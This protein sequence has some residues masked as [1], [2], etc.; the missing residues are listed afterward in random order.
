[1]ITRTRKADWWAPFIGQLALI[2]TKKGLDTT[3]E[4]EFKLC[5]NMLVK[6]AKYN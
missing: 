6:A 2:A 5:I 1:M 3:Y 4:L